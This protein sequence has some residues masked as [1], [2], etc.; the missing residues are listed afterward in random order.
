MIREPTQRVG[1]VGSDSGWAARVIG[2]GENALGGGNRMRWVVILIWG[3]RRRSGGQDGRG[4]RAACVLTELTM[5]IG[6]VEI[7]LLVLVVMR[8]MGETRKQDS[9]GHRPCEA[10]ADP[11]LREGAWECSHALAPVALRGETIEERRSRFGRFTF[12]RSRASTTRY[13]VSRLGCL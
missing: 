5:W 10:P 7:S 6:A 2:R 8:G 13:N 11:G 3:R 4:R 1:G 9:E 12:V